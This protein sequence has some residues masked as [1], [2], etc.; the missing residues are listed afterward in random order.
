GPRPSDYLHQARE[1]PDANRPRDPRRFSIHAPTCP[2]PEYP[3]AGPVRRD[4]SGPG[5]VGPVQH[6]ERR[7]LGVRPD[8]APPGP[9]R[10]AYRPTGSGEELGLPATPRAAV[11]RAGRLP[12]CAGRVGL[13]HVGEGPER[14]GALPD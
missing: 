4:H 1:G 12:R 3:S 5:E 7:P 9:P 11:P 6:V 13:P 2:D 14:A 10:D 8:A